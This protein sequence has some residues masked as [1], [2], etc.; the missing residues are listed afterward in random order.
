MAAISQEADGAEAAKVDVH[1]EDFIA[2]A[3]EGAT[4]VGLLLD[5]MEEGWLMSAPSSHQ[6]D[7][8]Q[9]MVLCR[10]WLQQGSALGD[11]QDIVF[12]NGG[13]NA[14]SSRLR[15]PLS[16]EKLSITSPVKSCSCGC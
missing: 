10:Q 3:A 14:D 16:I 15:I 6:T 11:L 4:A 12:P 9:I 13:G 5:A 2:K 8:E 7:M 1:D